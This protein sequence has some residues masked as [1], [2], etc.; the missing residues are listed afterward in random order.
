M[1]SFRSKTF[2]VTLIMLSLIACSDY[3]D[4]KWAAE[5]YQKIKP[6]YEKYKK[7]YRETVEKLEHTMDEYN[8]KVEELQSIEKGYN[9][10]ATE[11][12][13][14]KIKNIN[15]QGEIDR[16]QRDL[17]IRKTAYTNIYD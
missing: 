10:I 4:I 8:L 6:K 15:L 9:K 12:Q 2:A 11:L 5:Q 13:S 3:D 7:K 16:L 17:N 1:L 14:E